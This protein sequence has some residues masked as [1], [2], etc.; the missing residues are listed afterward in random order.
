VGALYAINTAGAVAGTLATGFVLLPELGLRLTVYIGAATFAL[1]F[2]A[3]A[4]LARAAPPLAAAAA[5]ASLRPPRLH[6]ALPLVA[7]SGVVSFTY[8]VIWMRLLG[9]LLGGSIQGFATMLASFLLG[10]AL[11]SAAA[12]RLAR[13]PARAARGFALA[14]IGAAALSLLVFAAADRLPDLAREIG[15]GRTGSQAANALIAILGLLPGTLC[16]GAVFP[17]AVRLVARD[18]ADAAPVS[19]RVYAWSTLG[20]ICGALLSGYA[21]LPALRFAGAMGAAAALN[22]LLALAAACLVRPALRGVAGV[23]VAGLALLLL[24]PPATPWGVLRYRPVGDTGWTGDV[25]YYGVGRSSTVL[26]FDQVKEWRL[27]TNGL[28]E[29][30]ID[31]AQPAFN[32]RPTS[33]W[34]ALLPVLLRPEAR[35]MLIVGLGGGLTLEAAPSTLESIH[36]IELEPEVVRAHEH[37]AALRGTSP[38]ADPRV[39]LVLNDARGA[40]LLTDA[41]FDA[42]VS[43]PSH[44]WTMGASHLYT[45]EFFSLA[46]R[47]LEPGGIFVQWIGLAY[48]DA[49][50]L[51]S[52]VATLLEVF[53]HVSLF[54][55]QP[56]AVLFAA[57]DAPL[58]PL[59]AAARAL[60]RAPDDFA[61]FGLRVVEDVAAGWVLDARDAGRFAAGAHIN[62]DDHNQLATRSAGL[63]QEA[64]HAVG[65]KR[66]LQRYEPLRSADAALQRTYLVR[67]LV[68]RKEAPRAA[69]LA[70]RLGDPV[71]RM[72]ALGWARSVSDPRRAAELFRR[73]VERDPTAQS[74]RFGLLRV[75]RRA[76]ESDEPAYRALAAPLEGAAAALVAGWRHAATQDWPALRALEPA[77]AATDVRDPGYGDALRLRAQWRNASDDP[78]LRAQALEIA[79]EMLRDDL[80]SEDVVVA[81]QAFAAAG[82]RVQALQ[83]LDQL[84]HARRN[85]EAVRA[86]VALFDA[87]VSDAEAAEW[88]FLRERLIQGVE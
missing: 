25:T 86:G 5:P 74:A 9:Y 16:I 32:Q 26:L 67:R 21:L 7:L 68:A 8:E 41:R 58:D 73:A 31:R 47:H 3:A 60:V 33:R 27:T 54:Q 57:S 39:H 63:G 11:G 48:V 37:L 83:L 13:D 76:V 36:V 80:S 6:W 53:P 22:L 44:P 49:V 4:L 18:A 15:A 69:R 12:A 55:P 43:Q 14:Q 45:R 17:F 52:L 66:L 40:L 64:L 84:S 70:S 24:L 78:A 50:L 35:S 20:A 23:A 51:R 88:A 79:T 81:A 71:E 56:G 38:L 65:G 46:A 87:L 2:C 29:S 34:L 75:Q 10:I 59:A 42:I 62:T 72:T 28:P 82:Q 19:A 1:V 30:E 77:L 61:R 85:R